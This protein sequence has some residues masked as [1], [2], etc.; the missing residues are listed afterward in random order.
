MVVGISLCIKVGEYRGI[1]VE[2][3]SRVEAGGCCWGKIQ[4]EV[5]T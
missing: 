3:C 1:A 5:S 4:Y 2:L